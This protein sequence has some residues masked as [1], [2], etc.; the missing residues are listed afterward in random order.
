MGLAPIGCTPHYLWEYKS[1]NGECV[2]AI[3]NVVVNF[4]YAMRYMVD[5]LNRNLSDAM[6]IF[7][8]AFE[9]S[10][11]ILANRRRYGEAQSLPFR[12]VHFFFPFFLSMSFKVIS[13]FCVLTDLC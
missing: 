2:D 10:M 6:I 1:V 7:Y 9:G 13:P 4:N 8:D 11:D 12:F 5:E 3:N